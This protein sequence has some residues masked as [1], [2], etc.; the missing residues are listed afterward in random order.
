MFASHE[1]FVRAAYSVLLGRDPEPAGLQYWTEML[2]AGQRP[3]AIAMIRAMLASEEFRE[4]LGSSGDPR[5]CPDVDVIIPIDGH[6][7][8]VPASDLSIVPTLLDSRV[9]EP[10][11]LDYLRAHLRRDHVFMDVGANLGYFTV[12]CAPLVARVIAVEPVARPG[13]YCALNITANDLAN[14]ELLPYGLWHEDTS[15]LVLDDPLNIGAGSLS[16]SG[17][18]LIQCRALDGL[19]ERGELSLPRL[20]M[21]KMDIQGA[22]VSALAGMRQTIA[23]CRPGIIMEVERT[24]LERLG[25]SVNDVWDAVDGLGYRLWAFEAWKDAPPKP[26][27]S[28]GKLESLCSLGSSIDVLMLPG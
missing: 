22:E 28:L 3:I 7:M 24:C 20:D 2:V 26:V 18:E 1:D 9:W 23:R 14:V 8:R 4:R 15:F 6:D 5:R 10:H 16:Q 25:R 11:I 19:V 13:R 21:V 27:D 17:D 12:L